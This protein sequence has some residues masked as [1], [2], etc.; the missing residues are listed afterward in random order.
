MTSSGI[1]P[2][3]QRLVS[4][5][6]PLTLRLLNRLTAACV[7]TLLG[8]V[9]FV[10]GLLNGCHEGWGDFDFGEL[11]AGGILLAIGIAFFIVYF[12]GK[13]MLA[14]DIEAEERERGYRK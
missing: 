10:L 7:M 2:G 6:K 13:R 5:G 1:Q 9:F 12:V 14:P 11:Y 4:R 8:V 3:L